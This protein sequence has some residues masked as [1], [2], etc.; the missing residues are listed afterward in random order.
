MKESKGKSWNK[1]CGELVRRPQQKKGAPSKFDVNSLLLNKCEKNNPAIFFNMNSLHGDFLY[2]ITTRSFI[3]N[4]SVDANWVIARTQQTQT[5]FLDLIS[6]TFRGEFLKIYSSSS[7]HLQNV[8]ETRFWC[9]GGMS[10]RTKCLLS[11]LFIRSSFYSYRN[12][13]VSSCILIE[14]SILECMGRR[15]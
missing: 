3:L 15:P 14:N 10:G 6:S 9:L 1:W 5:K 11:A 13:M 4:F 12:A 2:Y 7:W 8:S